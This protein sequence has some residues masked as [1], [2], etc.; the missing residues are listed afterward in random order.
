MP[1]FKGHVTWATPLFE[2]IVF[3]LGDLRMPRWC[4]LPSVKSRFTGFGY[5]VESMPSFLRVTWPILRS[6]WGKFCL[7][8]FKFANIKQCD[9][10]VCCCVIH[11]YNAQHQNAHCTCTVSRVQWVG[12]QRQP[13]IWNPR[14]RL[15]ELLR[16]FVPLSDSLYNFDLLWLRVVYRWASPL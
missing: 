14:P 11:C 1:K 12:G 13:L 8:A 16:E 3:I 5:I 2:K 15:K 6:F 4:C 10:V 7:T 9:V